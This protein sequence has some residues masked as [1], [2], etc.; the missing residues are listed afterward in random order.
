MAGAGFSV[1]SGRDGG[2]RSLDSEINM[3]PMIDLLMVT[4]SFLLITALWS[5]MGRLNADAQVLGPPDPI[6]NPVVEK[7]LH[8][9]MREPDKFVLVWKQGATVVDTIV[10]PRDD[11]KSVVKDGTRSTARFPDLAAQVAE[12]WK[13]AGAHRDPGDRA[14]DQVVLHTDDKTEYFKIVGVLDAI[15]QTKRPMTARGKTEPVSAFK[16]AFSAR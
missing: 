2:R 16:V 9:E 7:L 11:G 13:S 8:V 12:Q 3:I 6:A 4:I 5:S 14:L 10:V 15:Y 1:D